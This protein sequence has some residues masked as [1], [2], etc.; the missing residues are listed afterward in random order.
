MVECLNVVAATSTMQESNGSQN[1]IVGGTDAH[2]GQ[3]PFQLGFYD[4]HTI[5]TEFV[6]GAILYHNDTMITSGG[7]VRYFNHDNPDSLVVVAGDLNLYLDEETEQRRTVI[8]IISHEGYNPETHENDIALLKID[9]PFDL[10]EYVSGVTLPDK[11]QSFSGNAF[12][13]GWGTL[14]SGGYRPLVLQYVNVPIVSDEACRSGYGDLAWKIKD[15]MICAG[16][17]GKGPC[18][19]DG[20]GPMICGDYLC[21]ITNWGYGCGLAGYPGVFT[22]VSYFVDWIQ[23]NE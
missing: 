12:V 5:P 18:S 19:G 16:E 6:C 17:E 23:A 3:F 9:R 4:G 1:K 7:C 13:S 15:Y 22:E 8:R 2:P 10:N 14:S 20:G 11:L 21:G